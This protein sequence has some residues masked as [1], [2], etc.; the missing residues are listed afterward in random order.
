MKIFFGLIVFLISLTA[1][2][3]PKMATEFRFYDI[4][5]KTKGDIK[6]ELYKRTPII[7]NGKRFRGDTKWHVNW[8][9]K[10]KKK[11][12]SCQIYTVNTDLTIQ[13]TMPKISD[14]F[15]VD[16]G[17]RSSFDKYYKALLKHE[18]GHKNSGLYAARDIEKELLSLG[19][20][21]NCRRLE[22]IAN[23]KGK[24]IIEKY[25]QRD[26]DYDQRTDHGRI[27]GVNINLYIKD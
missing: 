14:D 11:K 25:N 27:E 3:E 4:Y 10:W 24:N 12:G 16:S 18:Q 22:K 8:K 6:Q 9:F 17:I 1:I 13:Y 2:S 15:P 21:N 20:F 19:E 5:P 26:K 7:L 23:N